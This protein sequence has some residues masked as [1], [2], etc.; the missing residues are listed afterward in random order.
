M[1]KTLITLFVGVLAF[2]V[3]TGV[4]EAQAIPMGAA[5]HSGNY[6]LGD[7]DLGKW[8]IGAYY[9]DR[10]RDITTL[11]HMHSMQTTKG[12]AYVGYEIFYG[13]SAF[14]TVGS[15]ETQFEGRNR[16]DTHSEYGLGLQFNILDHQIPDPGLMEDRIRLNG[17]LQYT[18]SG[19]DWVATEIDWEEFYASL[20]LGLVNDISGNKAFNMQNIGFFFGAVYSHLE[21]SGIEEDSAFG[22]TAG[23]SIRFSEKV[24]FEMGVESLDQGAIFGGVHIG[25]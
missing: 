19:A 1:K 25:L 12:M 13:M 22:Y 11:G 24:S 2:T 14:V 15:T 17:S 16:T 21:S 9:L 6:F 4:K 5:E 3:L 8:S 18:Q 7:E 10:E 20:T 23:V